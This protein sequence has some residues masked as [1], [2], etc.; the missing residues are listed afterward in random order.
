MLTLSTVTQHRVGNPSHSDQKRKRKPPTLEKK[1]NSVFADDYMWTIDRKSRAVRINEFSTVAG[2]TIDIQKPIV[3]S[4]A[5][6][7]QTVRRETK[8]IIQL[9]A[10]S[11][12][13]RC[14]GIS[15]I[16]EAKHLHSENCKTL[17]KETEDDP[18]RRKDMY[19]RGLKEYC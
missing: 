3:I 6:Y 12:R 5:N 18:D 4:I 8:K 9:T 15:L 16:K 2:Y 17:T 7:Q 13:R 10:A 11:E 1:Q 14:L 19:P